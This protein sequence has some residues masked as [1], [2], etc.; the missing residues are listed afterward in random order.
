MTR[1]HAIERA[2]HWVKVEGKDWAVFRDLTPEFPMTDETPYYCAP[3]D[4][5]PHQ[6]EDWGARLI[7]TFNV[8]GSVEWER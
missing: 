6:T 1:E 5:I 3:A 4:D 7:V 2:K 8:D